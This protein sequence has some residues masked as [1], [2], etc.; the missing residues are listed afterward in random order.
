M[1]CNAIITITRWWGVQFREKNRYVT[2]E[3]PHLPPPQFDKILW[4][5]W[6][7]ICFMTIRRMLCQK[8]RS[9]AYLH[10]YHWTLHKPTATYAMRQHKTKLCTLNT[11]RNVIWIHNNELCI[12]KE[13]C[14]MGRLVKSRWIEVG[15]AC[16]K[17][18]CQW[19]LPTEGGICAPWEG[20]EE[21]RKVVLEAARLHQE[22][23]HGG[24]VGKRELEDSHPR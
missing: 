10:T 18:G 7:R 14:L 24:I 20:K 5:H 9:S 22:G 11:G 13:K 15:E 6:S 8:G 17:N 23:H 1:L 12:Q 4:T 2:L 19:R 16:G 21:D 3:W